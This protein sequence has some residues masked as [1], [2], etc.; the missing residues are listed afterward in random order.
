MLFSYENVFNQKKKMKHDCKVCGKEAHDRCSRCLCVYYCTKECQMKDWKEGGHK[1][2]CKPASITK[3]MK[4]YSANK[5][6]GE[7]VIGGRHVKG[8][9]DG[10]FTVSYKKSELAAES[11]DMLIAALRK[12]VNETR[13]IYGIVFPFDARARV[14]T[15]ISLITSEFPYPVVDMYG[16][17]G[18]F[19]GSAHYESCEPLLHGIVFVCLSQHSVIPLFKFTKMEDCGFFSD[20]MSKFPPLYEEKIYQDAIDIEWFWTMEK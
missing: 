20:P 5:L 13:R 15:A 19:T 3:S 17:D 9:G 8:H 10:M 12:S 11:S 16:R 18:R 2:S 4:F 7:Q 14:D 6:K 1:S